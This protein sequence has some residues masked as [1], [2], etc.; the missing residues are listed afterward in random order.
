MTAKTG[1]TLIGSDK[2]MG[3]AAEHAGYMP[4]ISAALR[5]PSAFREQRHNQ[6]PGQIRRL[7][8]SCPKRR[9]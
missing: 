1:V 9:V 7:A 2:I 4:L 6:Q 8:G 5:S 3:A